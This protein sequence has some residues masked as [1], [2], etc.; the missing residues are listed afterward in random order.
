MLA[1]S[2]TARDSSVRR[3]RLLVG[4]AAAVH[5]QLQRRDDRD[6]VGV[7]AALA[8]AV[9]RA[10][11]LRAPASTAA[12]A[13]ATARSQSLC[14]WMPSAR[15]DRLAHDAAPPRRRRSGRLPPLVSHSTIQSAPASAAALTRRQRV[16]AVGAEAV[17][18]VLGVVDH[19]AA[20]RASGRRRSRAIIARFSSSVVPSTFG[21]VQGPRL[22]DDARRP[23]SRRRPARAGS[24]RPRPRRRPCGSCRTPSA[25]RA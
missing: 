20:L 24:G 23:A 9:D 4:D 14:V 25:W 12:S 21:D 13:L 3:A 11:H 17:E 7:A 8:E 1:I 10:L 2:L 22:A 6:Q 16:V 15:G 18:E 5:L 19:L